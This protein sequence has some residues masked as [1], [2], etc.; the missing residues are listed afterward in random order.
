MTNGISF[1]PECLAVVFAAWGLWATVTT[2]VIG[3]ML[4]GAALIFARALKNAAVPN[5]E[6]D[7]GDMGLLGI[8]K[9]LAEVQPAPVLEPVVRMAA[10]VAPEPEPLIPVE[11]IPKVESAPLPVTDAI[12]VSAAEPVTGEQEKVI[13]DELPAIEVANVSQESLIAQQI[14]REIAERRARLSAPEERPVTQIVAPVRQTG[15][16]TPPPA[17]PERVEV[18]SATARIDSHTAKLQPKPVLSEQLPPS[19][20]KLRPPTPST[21]EIPQSAPNVAVAAPVAVSAAP[22]RSETGD[23]SDRLI[24]VEQFPRITTPLTEAVGPRRSA[25]PIE[26]VPNFL[27]EDGGIENIGYERRRLFLGM[28]VVLVLFAVVFSIFN[29]S[30]RTKIYG[31]TFGERLAAIPRAIGFE[32]TPPPPLPAKLVEIKEFAA[33]YKP[34]DKKDV[35]TVVKTGVVKNIGPV[36]LEGLRVEIEMFP[37]EPNQPL[38]L[39]TIFLVPAVLE[40]NQEGNFKLEFYDNQVSRISIKRVL[41]S[42]KDAQGNEV[43]KELKGDQKMGMEASPEAPKDKEEDARKKSASDKAAEKRM[44]QAF[45]DETVSGGKTVHKKG[46]K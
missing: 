34:S 14:A 4:I 12:T 7:E 3:I 25:Q 36:K 22:V 18:S 43:V 42:E 9:P 10:A 46:K 40:P 13:T 37:R 23:V 5:E 30:L 45:P 19:N 32:G 29:A 38:E 1:S 24:P 41:G 33:F 20:R 28:A 35:R 2:I 17:P 11:I 27:A 31:A 21:R 6:G 44:Q 26:K 39:R 8:T 15:E 16:L